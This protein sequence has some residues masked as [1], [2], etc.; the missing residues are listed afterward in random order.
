MR[1]P[2]AA[3][4]SLEIDAGTA[5]GG[6]RDWAPKFR[7]ANCASLV[8]IFEEHTV[9]ESLLLE[10]AR[11]LRDYFQSEGYFDAEVE[12][13]PQRIINDK[14]SIDYLINPGKRHKLVLIEIEGNQYFRTEAIRERMFLMRASLLQFRHGRYSGVV[15]APRRRVHRQ[16]VPI[17]R[18]SRRGGDAQ[19]C[20]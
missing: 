6:A 12:F 2:T 4:L 19:D 8:P 9:D 18:I 10:G 13:K 1:T 14:A 3:G 20:G 11:N 15:A 5:G 7:K 17:E 16:P